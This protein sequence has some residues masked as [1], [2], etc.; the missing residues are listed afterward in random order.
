MVSPRYLLDTNIL[1]FLLRGRADRTLA[2]RM[3]A[4]ASRLAVSSIT[5]AELEYGVKRSSTPDRERIAV[6]AVLSRCET[7]S[8]GQDAAVHAG[9]IRAHLASSG[10]PIGSY[11]T[12]IAAH[13]RSAGLT[14]VTNYAREFMRVPGLL[15]ED[16]T[17]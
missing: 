17:A 7:L 15:M 1:I 14:V 8:F 2:E 11:D 9:E 16:W 5:V 12:L 10:T 13:A 4:Q 6:D 3:Q